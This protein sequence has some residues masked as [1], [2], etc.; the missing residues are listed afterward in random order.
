MHSQKIKKPKLKMKR[1]SVSKVQQVKLKVQEIYLSLI[2]EQTLSK[3]DIFEYYVNRIWFGSGNN[4]RGIQKAAQYF[5][6][7]DV[8]QLNLGESAFLAGCINAPDT[9]NPLNNLNS[10][11]TVDHLSLA[12]K[13]R[14]VT[15]ELMMNHGYITE[16]EYNLAA[17]QKLEFA[18]NYTETTSSDPNQAYIT[19]TLEEVMEL[20]GQD[21]AIIPMDIY[22]A[23][24]QDVQKQA[25]EICNGNIVT[26]PNEAFDVGFSMIDNETGEIIA[27]GPGRRYHSDSVKVDNSTEPQQ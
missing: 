18:I 13:R 5:F 21:P 16:E 15:L 14:N 11:N 7:K 4:T 27:V 17:N 26:F 25:D 20:T 2:A 1:G 22:T 8:S 3:E 12:T 23:L 24:N 10:E 6:G 9:Y 19:Q